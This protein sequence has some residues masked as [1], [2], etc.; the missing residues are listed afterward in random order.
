MET[1]CPFCNR[2]ANLSDR[3]FYEDTAAGWFAFLSAPRTQRAMQSSPRLEGTG[4]A[5]KGLL[6]KFFM[7]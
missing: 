5:L 6:R 3:V 7:V 4:N 1:S 2:D